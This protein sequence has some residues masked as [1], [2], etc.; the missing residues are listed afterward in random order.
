MDKPRQRPRYNRRLRKI[1]QDLVKEPPATDSG[2]ARDKQSNRRPSPSDKSTDDTVQINT[3]SN[4]G[5]K[6][7][8][9]QVYILYSLLEDWPLV[10]GSKSL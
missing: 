7:A 10:P 8:A 1:M 4:N 6:L 9:E 3:E 2:N 5:N